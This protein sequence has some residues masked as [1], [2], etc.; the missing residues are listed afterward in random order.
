MARA[1]IVLNEVKSALAFMICIPDGA[2]GISMLANGIGA[3]NCQPTFRDLLRVRSNVGGAPIGTCHARDHCQR[4]L[5]HWFLSPPRSIRR[6]FP[7]K[8]CFHESC[9]LTG[10][11]G[12]IPHLFLQFFTSSFSVVNNDK[13]KNIFCTNNCG[14]VFFKVNWKSSREKFVSFVNKTVVYNY[15]LF[16]YVF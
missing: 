15:C 10:G 13:H 12:R 6:H 8:P 7:R 14:W 1:R 3:Q 16:I 2:H 4:R 11:H 9:T 5:P